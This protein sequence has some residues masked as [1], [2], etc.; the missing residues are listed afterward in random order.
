MGI[1]DLMIPSPDTHLEYFY[2][3]RKDPPVEEINKEDCGCYETEWVSE[4][5]HCW[6]I[7][8]EMVTNYFSS[9]EH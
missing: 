3:A 2:E 6:V 9:P 5:D 8:T 7:Y 1:S 4:S